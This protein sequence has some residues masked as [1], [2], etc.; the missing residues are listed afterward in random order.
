MKRVDVAS[1]C[2]LEVIENDVPLVQQLREPRCV[3]VI[4]L[5]TVM[6]LD[7][8]YHLPDTEDGCHIYFCVSFLL[9]APRAR[10]STVSSTLILT[11]TSRA[12]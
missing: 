5:L 12:F 3:A 6:T 11:R 4:P 9:T 7:M 1:F 8:I 2:D 10:L